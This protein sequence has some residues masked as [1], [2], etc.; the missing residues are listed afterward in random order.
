MRCLADV[1]LKALERLA[2]EKPFRFFERHSLQM[3]GRGLRGLKAKVSNAHRTP[4]RHQDSTLDRMIE[5][6]NV[7]RP[8]VS[9]ERLLCGIIKP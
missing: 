4:L 6:A 7:T 9:L 1:A 8:W 3:L 2:D 5:L